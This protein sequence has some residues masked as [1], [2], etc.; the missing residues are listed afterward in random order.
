M[1]NQ[2]IIFVVVVVLG[3]LALWKAPFG[4]QVYSTGGNK[5]ASTLAG[6]DTDRVRILSFTICGFLAA[7]SGLIT[8]AKLRSYAPQIGLGFELNVIAA[9]IVGGVSIFGGRGSVLGAIVGAFVLGYLNS[10]ITI[11]VL[12]GSEI[13]SLPQRWLQIIIGGIIIGAVLFDIWVRDEKIFG[14]LLSRL[15]GRQVVAEAAEGH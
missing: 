12:V 5:R 13:R 9:V 3:A 7:L 1:P 14:R 2:V 15:R 4:Y 10:I 8:V 6:I 11:G